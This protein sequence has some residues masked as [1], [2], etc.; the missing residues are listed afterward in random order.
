M[1]NSILV[2]PVELLREII[3]WAIC[4]PKRARLQTLCM[5]NRVFSAIV[6]P[7][8]LSNL[9]LGVDSNGHQDRNRQV[10]ILALGAHPACQLATTITLWMSSETGSPL[11]ISGQ[12]TLKRAITNCSR[13]EKIIW[14]LGPGEPPWVQNEVLSALYHLSLLKTLHIHVKPSYL[15]RLRLSTGSNLATLTSL[16]IEYLS[17]GY[18]E[19]EAARQSSGRNLSQLIS[20][21]PN[22]VSLEVAFPGLDLTDIFPGLRSGDLS[23]VPPI[24]HLSL[25]G[26]GKIALLRDIPNIHSLGIRLDPDADGAFTG[27]W[28]ILRLRNTFPSRILTD[29]SLYESD[30]L[31]YLY[32]HPHLESLILLPVNPNYIPDA[33][34]EHHA[35][36]RLCDILARHSQHLVEFVLRPSPSW[37]PPYWDWTWVEARMKPALFACRKLQRLGFRIPQSDIN[38][39]RAALVSVSLTFIVVNGA[40]SWNWH[41]HA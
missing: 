40:S 28:N 8:M 1:D 35:L 30:L 34:G 16:R 19:N 31:N 29:R 26:I 39:M 9:I 7:M 27:I 15:Y 12:R 2:L 17:L 37:Y 18:F 33:L 20:R 32:F 36:T 13:L 38:R 41:I 21:C 24:R 4:P 10:Q 22:L 6:Q 5:V 14:N 11:S 25:F 3:E 23:R